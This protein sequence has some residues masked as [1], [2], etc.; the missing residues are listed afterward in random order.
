M[1]QKRRSKCE[2]FIEKTRTRQQ[3]ENLV[4][5]GVEAQS[6]YINPQQT[7]TDKERRKH[8]GYTVCKKW[9]QDTPRNNQ[10]NNQ[11]KKLQGTTKHGTE[12]GSNTKVQTRHEEC[13]TLHIL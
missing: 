1:R 11:H 4:T 10:G 6:V 13:I 7:S 2:G 5:R 8:K 9:V 3:Q 12:T